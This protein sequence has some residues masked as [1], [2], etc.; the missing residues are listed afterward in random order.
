MPKIVVCEFILN[1]SFVIVCNKKYHHVPMSDTRVC[2]SSF[3]SIGNVPYK[4]FPCD[5]FLPNSQPFGFCKYHLNYSLTLL[6]GMHTLSVYRSLFIWFF[7]LASWS[8]SEATDRTIPQIRNLC[9]LIRLTICRFHMNA[10]PPGFNKNF[11]L[12]T[13]LSPPADAKLK[14]MPSL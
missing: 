10:V 5:L 6:L 12:L 2:P 3:V 7:N 9:L 4:V 13:V 14:L 8:N 1:L 11:A